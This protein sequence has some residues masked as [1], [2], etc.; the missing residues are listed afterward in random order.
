[1]YKSTSI[2]QHVLTI[3]SCVVSSELPRGVQLIAKCQQLPCGFDVFEET[4]LLC[5]LGIGQACNGGSRKGI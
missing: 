5:I 3:Q 2:L 1:M 4:I